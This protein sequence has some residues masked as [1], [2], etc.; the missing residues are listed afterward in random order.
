[1]LQL[2]TVLVKGFWRRCPPNKAVVF[3]I[4][5][6]NSWRHCDAGIEVRA[7]NNCM[8][9]ITLTVQYI[10]R[11]FVVFVYIRGDGLLYVS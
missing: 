3:I 1:M 8:S 6:D 11:Y 7:I 9:I 5:R 4:A 2:Q 10:S